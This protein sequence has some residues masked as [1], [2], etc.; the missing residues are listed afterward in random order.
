MMNDE[1]LRERLRRL[2]DEARSRAEH[3][4]I[5]RET[6]ERA[7]ADEIISSVP[8]R[9]EDEAARGKT[10]LVVMDVT[11]VE[12]PV[13]TDDNQYAL[14]PTSLSGPSRYVW[15]WCVENALDPTLVPRWTSLDS[16]V[17]RIDFSLIVRW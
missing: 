7:A 2:T 10:C 12:R 13:W 3:E 11:Y 15:D 5:R 16:G 14:D 6:A 1:P 17:H 8:Q 9:A 4:R